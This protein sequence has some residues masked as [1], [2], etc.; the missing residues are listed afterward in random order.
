MKRLL[1]VAV[2]LL[3]TAPALAQT[4]QD[5]VRY[6][7]LTPSGTARF[8]GVGGAF[9]ALGADFAS[10]SQ[11]PAGMAMYRASELA[12]TPGLKFSHTDATLAGGESFEDDKSSFY[13]DHVG[14]VFNTTP[15]S[16]R[17]KVDEGGKRADVRGWQTFNVGIGFN[18]LAS[19]NQTAYYVG[20]A[21]GSILTGFFNSAANDINNGVPEDQLDPFGAQLAY[22]ANAVYFQDNELTYDFAG[23]DQAPVER[24]Q[25]VSTFGGI[26]E[27]AFS[28]SGNYA[29]KLMVGVT[30]GVPFVNYRLEGEYTESDPSDAVAYFDRLS[31]TE[32]LRTSG[33]G[34]NFK[35]GF[36]YRIS[37]G[38]RFGGAF[39]TPTLYG[40][41]DNYYNSFSYDYTDGSGAYQGEEQRSPDGVSDYRLRSPWRAMAGLSYLF[42]KYGFVSADVE[43]VD[44]GAGRFNL[45][46]DVPNT[47]N[48]QYE[49]E[50]N[51]SLQRAY[52]SAVNVRVGGELALNQFRLRAGVNLLGSPDGSDYS[53]AISGGAGVRGDAFF[54]DIG[55]RHTLGDGRLTPY[56]GAPT[57]VLDTRNGELLLTLG[58]KF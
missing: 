2:A 37:Q 8:L 44:Y 7:Q 6:S 31:Y 36:I 27:L 48:E 13:L 49:R 52:N 9:T 40:L 14:I 57:A 45:T 50:L 4:I 58:F 10:A 29:E 47:E 38:L 5:A 56:A 1:P 16:K 53:T 34:V 24:S 22:N 43:W 42:R 19:F 20:T 46:A 12:I 28:L 15:P 30:V 35:L 3:L 23:N 55:Y 51:Q 54:L 18:R 41:T 21:P 32:Y 17:V 26:N 25:T 39:H 11:N 33:I